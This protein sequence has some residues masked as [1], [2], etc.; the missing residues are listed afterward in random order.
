MRVSS[1]LITKKSYLRFRNRLKNKQ[2]TLKQSILQKTNK[3]KKPNIRL[4]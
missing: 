2:V 4:P 3:K 1:N